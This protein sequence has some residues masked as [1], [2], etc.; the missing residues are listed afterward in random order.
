MIMIK[1]SHTVSVGAKAIQRRLTIKGSTNPTGPQTTG[2]P[3]T[4]S[5]SLDTSY[6]QLGL[7]LVRREGIEPP[8]R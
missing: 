4:P 8:T 3:S 1:R 5:A 2:G 6:R 7:E